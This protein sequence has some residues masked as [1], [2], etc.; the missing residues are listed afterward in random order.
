MSWKNRSQHADALET[1]TL[2]FMQIRPDPMEYKTA[3]GIVNFKKKVKLIE[4]YMSWIHQTFTL[5]KVVVQYPGDVIIS[6]VFLHPVDGI[7]IRDALDSLTQASRTVYPDSE[8]D[9]EVGVPIPYSFTLD[10]W[11]AKDPESVSLGPVRAE[12]F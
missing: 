11:A 9:V 8:E 4:D 10:R 1:N 12:D 6:I 2:G 7:E 3:N 5:A